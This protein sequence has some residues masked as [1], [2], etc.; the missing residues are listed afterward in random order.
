MDA[1]M[2]DYWLHRFN[3]MGLFVVDFK[4]PEYS[5]FVQDL[6]GVGFVNCI[7]LLGALDRAIE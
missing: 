1:N 5:E 4:E 3:Q 7:Q 6:A 2:I